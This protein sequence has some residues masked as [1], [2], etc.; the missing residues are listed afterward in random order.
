M[1]RALRVADLAGFE[2]PD[3]P[4]ISPDGRSVVYV[5]RTVDLDGDRYVQTLWSVGIDGSVPRRLTMGPSDASPAFSPDGRRLVFL[6]FVDGFSQLWLLP[7]DGGEPEQLTRLPLGAAAARWSPDGTRLAFTAPVDLAAAGLGDGAV[8]RERTAP[9]VT[10]RLDYLGDGSGVFG[11]VRAH[12]HVVDVRSGA[13]RQLTHGDRHA[14]D[15]VWSPDGEQLAF[16]SARSAQSDRTG[17]AGVYVVSLAEPSEPARIGPEPASLIPVVWGK[18]EHTLFAVGTAGTPDQPAALLRLRNDEVVSLSESL[19]RTVMTGGPAY[20]GGLPQL[21]SDDSALLFCARDAGRTGLYRVGV[22]GGEITALPLGADT[23]VAALAV[24]TG[25]PCAAV[26]LA[27][28]DSFGEITLVDLETGTCRELTDYRRASLAGVALHPRVART[29]VISDGTVVQ[30]WLTRDDARRGPRPLLLDIHG[31]PHNAW[32]AA[33]DEMHVY[34]QA[35]VARGW[36]V[37][38]LNARGSDGYGADFYRALTARWGE[39]DAADFREPIDEL[40]AEGIADPARLAVTGYSYGGF[41]T[42][43]LTSHDNRFAAAVAGGAV[44]NLVSLAGTSDAGHHIARFEIGATPEEQRERFDRLSP[45]TRVGQVHTPTLLLHGQADLRCPV[46]QAQEWFTALRARGIASRLVIYPAASHLFPVNGR[47]SHRIDYGERVVDWLERYAGHGATL[48]REPWRQRLAASAERHRVPGAVLG[49]LRA[50]DGAEDELIVAD[51]GVLN[52]ETQVAV[53]PDSLF[54]IGSITK[55][56]TATLIMQLVDEGRLDLDAPVRAVLPEL[57]L[58]DERTTTGLTAR[59]LLTHTSGIDGDVFSD[60]GDG[61]DCLERY[62]ALLAGTAQLFPLGATHSYSNAG[63]AVLGRIVEV[64]TG[65]T[66]EDALHTRLATPLGLT[67][68]GASARHAIRHRAAIGHFADDDGVRPA[69]SWSLPRATNPFGG[70]TSSVADLLAFA[71]M[72]LRGGIAAD[73]T[74]VLSTAATEMMA[75]HCAALPAPVGA[76]RSWGLG[77][78]R[79]D[80]DG[81]ELLGHNGATIGQSAFLL[82]DR[83]SRL[84][85]AL[86]TNGADATEA[87]R[88]VG[89]AAFAELAGRQIPD[90]PGPPARPVRGGSPQRHVGR[91]VRA[92]VT[93]DVTVDGGQLLLRATL[94]GPLADLLP[95]DAQELPLVACG[96]GRYLFREPGDPRWTP[97]AFFALP[98]GSHYLYCGSRATPRVR[99]SADR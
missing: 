17:D 42:C 53:T 83:S 25:A 87:Y 21:T 32:N 71:A 4:T 63:Y 20:P 95:S 10:D 91:Y 56:W 74:R 31:G 14:G 2:I 99:S 59:H 47:P 66:W 18:D 44:T 61:D 65:Q 82:L 3:Q 50:A 86:L 9:V 46:G 69:A 96:P 58:A 80:W 68:T 16:G 51:C 64:L 79:H 24:A 26:V 11:S 73:G 78:A 72:H 85:I 49:I 75:A 90:L 48:Q 39:A 55:L 27:G 5:L 40:V 62:V 29:F 67:H 22:D 52:A 33:A 97:V 45:L 57:Q 54:Q 38:T 93:Y 84:A 70:I 12:L 6:R 15:P 94:T 7:I 35:L 34:H 81:A 19:D 41:M 89:G 30:G 43:Y 8:R 76:V 77:W 1:P 60:T 88:E 37:L 92:S 36:S 23:V 98:D 28:P 13:V